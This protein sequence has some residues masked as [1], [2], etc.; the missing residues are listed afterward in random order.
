[1]NANSIDTLGIF[2][3]LKKSSFTEDQAHAISEIFKDV[4]EENLKSIATKADLKYELT[5]LKYDLTLRMGGIMAA[6]VAILT[7]IIKLK[8]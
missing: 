5:Q 8:G 6:A 1:M 2:D 3:R 7:A 4:Q